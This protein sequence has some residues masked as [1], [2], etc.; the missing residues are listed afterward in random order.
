MAAAGRI[1]FA[2]KLDTGKDSAVKAPQVSLVLFY[3]KR[4]INHLKPK[5]KTFSGSVAGPVLSRALASLFMTANLVVNC[6]K[7]FPPLSFELKR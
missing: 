7:T 4:G 1:P 6:S 3:K 2:Q 5:A